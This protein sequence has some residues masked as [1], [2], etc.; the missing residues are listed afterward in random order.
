MSEHN[1]DDFDK[2]VDTL[3]NATRYLLVTQ[4]GCGLDD[5][6]ID[7]VKIILHSLDRIPVMSRG[8]LLP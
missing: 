5:G 8:A 4:H 2:A 6:T 3:D 7:A 1:K